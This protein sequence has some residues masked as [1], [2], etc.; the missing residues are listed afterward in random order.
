MRRFFRVDA[1]SLLAAAIALLVGFEVGTACARRD[2]LPLQAGIVSWGV[3]QGWADGRPF[4]RT[5]RASCGYLEDGAILIP[6]APR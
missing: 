3:C 6:A 4:G 1:R 2:P 5:G